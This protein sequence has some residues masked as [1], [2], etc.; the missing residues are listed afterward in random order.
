MATASGH[1]SAIRAKKVIGTSVKDTSGKKIGEI[2]DV[3]LDKQSNNIM[4][5]VVGF[6][7]FLGMAEKYHPLPWSALDYSESDGAYVVPYS[8][9]QLEAAPAG[10][11]DELTKG[12]GMAVRDRTYDYYKAPRYWEGNALR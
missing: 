12:D 6:G 5:A 4:F 10:S 8:K 2:E 7:G 3:V 9:S 1:T 11:I